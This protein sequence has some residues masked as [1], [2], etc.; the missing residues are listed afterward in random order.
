MKYKFLVAA[1]L[2]AMPFMAS[3]STSVDGRSFTVN[4][5]K[6]S[7]SENLVG[8]P[9]LDTP[10]RLT[11][12]EDMKPIQTVSNGVTSY[13][14]GWL[15]KGA[16]INPWKDFFYNSR[17]AAKNHEI[18]I[19]VDFFDNPENRFS[20]KQGI[21]TY[22]DDGVMY[23]NGEY[24]WQHMPNL[25]A[26]VYKAVIPSWNKG[27]TKSIYLPSRKFKSVEVFY[28]QDNIPLWD[29]RNQYHSI[30][31]EPAQLRSYYDLSE[32][33]TGTTKG[34]DVTAAPDKAGDPYRPAV[35]LFL[36]QKL[37]RNNANDTTIT[38]K[39]K[40]G[41]FNHLETS[42]YWT[43][44]VILLGGPGSER[45][46]ALTKSRYMMEDTGIF[47]N[48]LKIDSIDLKL[49]ENKR[50]GPENSTGTYIAS[51]DRTD[52]SMTPESMKFC[53]LD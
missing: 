3:S 35:S 37:T 22:T 27:E 12:T 53:G 28:F 42:L 52:F 30:K 5:A 2:A 11:F 23:S 24:Q 48:A 47:S 41:S 51:Y 19:Y 46:T 8:C 9:T 43:R 1:M 15:G 21:F 44:E 25:G 32:F 7:S 6:V 36:Y 29:K 50:I 34:G 13:Y 18:H 33:S 38:F 16:E 26:N 14:D 45:N 17:F 39:Q 49:M 20:D 4:K 40:R 10:L 31:N